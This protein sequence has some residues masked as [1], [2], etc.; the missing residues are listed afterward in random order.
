MRLGIFAIALWLAIGLDRGLGPLLRLGDGS[1]EPSFVLPLI[2]FVA[3][4][5]PARTAM[6]G[7]AAAGL[8]VD[9][10]SPVTLP[11][12]GTAVIPGPNALGLVLAVRLVLALRGQVFLNS[13]LTLV[14]LTPLA[15]TAWQ[16]TRAGIFAIREAYE[17]IGTAVLS[18]LGSGLLSSLLSAGSAF[19][20][21]FPL[22][23]CVRWFAFD[24]PHV[25]RWASA[26]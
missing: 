8:I 20:L 6:A 23:W 16:I 10:L 21:W 18:E 1:V 25:S 17:P 14:V 15:G 13:P 9:L 4:Y 22:M 12:G 19:V 2:V 26:R 24:A 11:A 5:A 3:L 7:A